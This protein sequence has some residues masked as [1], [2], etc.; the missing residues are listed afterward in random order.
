VKKGWL[1]IWVVFVTCGT[2]FSQQKYGHIDSEEIL[3]AMPEYKQLTNTV[4]NKRKAYALQF[5][6]MYEDY[7]RRG[8]ELQ[9][10]GPSMM[11]A[12]QEERK[13]EMDS[14]QQALQAFEGTA[15]GEIEKLQAKLLKP[16]NDKYLKIVQAVAKENGYTYIFDLSRGNIAYHPEI[17]GDIT[18]LVKKKMGIN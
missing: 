11:Q 1:L 18:S 5:Q 3:D 14:L 10:F 7:E 15:Q 12:I 2:A 9:E 6:R 8:K 4:E 13:M 17:E 16:L